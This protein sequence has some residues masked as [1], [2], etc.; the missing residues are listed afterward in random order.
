ML[1]LIDFVRVGL[2]P[3]FMLLYAAVDTI[4]TMAGGVVEVFCGPATKQLVAVW[5]SR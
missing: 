5:V 3:K 1:G 4:S 2:P